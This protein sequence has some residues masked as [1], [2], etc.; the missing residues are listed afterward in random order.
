MGF[1]V[2]SK[3]MRL[4][5]PNRIEFGIR[6]RLSNTRRFGFQRFDRIN[7]I[8]FNI[9]LIYFRLKSIKFEHFRFKFDILIDLNRYNVDYLIENSRFISKIGQIWSK[10]VQ[11]KQ[12]I[13]KFD[14]IR[15]DSMIFSP[16]STLDSKL[17]RDFESDCRDE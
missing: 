1:E 8:E 14:Q 7:L 15:P 5:F 12:I 2:P 3:L 13:L 16:K 9:K 10:N 17:D 11:N 6:I 4:G